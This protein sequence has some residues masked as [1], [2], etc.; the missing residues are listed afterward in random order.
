MSRLRTGIASGGTLG[1]GGGGGSGC[2]GA[3]EVGL[4]TPRGVR[5]S[6]PKDSEP[7]I[8]LSLRYEGP[9][10]APIAKGERVAELL[11]TV[12]GMPS[13][14][15]PLVARE[16]VLEATVI[17]RVFNAFRSWLA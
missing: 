16:E 1:G 4:T 15:V 9:L 13:Y 3:S 6:V 17:Q 10:R 12:T 2:G 8:S 14:R 5:V 7:E 11:V